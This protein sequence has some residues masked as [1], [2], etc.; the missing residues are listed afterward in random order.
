[1]INTHI[2]ERMSDAAAITAAPL[3]PPA[4][5]SLAAAAPRTRRDVDLYAEGNSFAEPG[6]TDTEIAALFGKDG[7]G[8]KDF[9]DI[10]NPLQHLP[11]V[12]T[13][14]RALT[15]DKLEPGSRILGGTLFG[16]IG[17]FVTSLANAV[18]E[19]ETGS[20]IGDKALAFFR[21]N[22][23]PETNVAQGETPTAAAATAA[24]ATTATPEV[25]QPQPPAAEHKTLP[26][27]AGPLTKLAKVAGAN[28][29]APG[30]ENPTEALIRARATVP[31]LRGPLFAGMPSAAEHA[32]VN[33]APRPATPAST[34][35]LAN[36]S[37]PPESGPQAAAA[38]AASASDAAPSS[39]TPD[40]AYM[41]R[42]AL[43]K[44]E[45]LMKQRAG[46]SISSEF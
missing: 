26:I 25:S 27:F 38:G 31:A 22:D 2:H 42:E 1:M 8:F 33:Q 3:V 30:A 9:L 40:I 18:I 14:Y 21:G 24:P 46:H 29:V 43:D 5:S 36:V 15:G 39:P 12:G 35:A 6:D 32:A 4:T 37:P 17:G 10:I 45:A 44:Y 41:M 20:D 16:G 13:L 7:F 34:L 23:T 19:N 28:A 11:V